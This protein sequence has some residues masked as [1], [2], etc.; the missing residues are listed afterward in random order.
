M[1]LNCK[2]LT[3]ENITVIIPQTEITKIH[4][5]EF[6]EVFHDT[7]VSSKKKICVFRN[8]NQSFLPDIENFCEPF[9]IVF[10]EK[11]CFDFIPDLNPNKFILISDLSKEVIDFC[12]VHQNIEFV[13]FYWYRTSSNYAKV[14]KKI[15]TKSKKYFLTARM[16][17]P[18][19][20]KV[21]LLS[22]LVSLEHLEW[23]SLQ[24]HDKIPGSPRLFESEKN[25]G[26]DHEL[27]SQEQILSYV[28]LCLEYD[29][30][31]ITEKTYQ[32]LYHLSPTIWHTSDAILYLEQFGLT[33]RFNGFDYSYLSLPRQD[34]INTLVQQIKS[35]DQNDF[36]D[37]Y[38]QNVKETQ[39][40]HDIMKSTKHWYDFFAP[41]VKKYL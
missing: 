5:F 38:H 28:L 20:W 31:L 15:W 26:I 12:D 10:L 27:P 18:R 2:I 3:K 35:M 39:N 22:D 9:D 6:D 30:S 32:H 19:S 34:K 25:L 17:N 4:H 29:N 1:I 16:N 23:S 36:E 41:K 14:N 37:F 24:H 13:P 21:D 33:V 8:F 11:E 40:N 7:L